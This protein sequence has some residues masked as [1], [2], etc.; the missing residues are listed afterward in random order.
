MTDFI[1]SL[2]RTWVAIA[3]GWLIS[4]GV[5]SSSLSD[6]AVQALTGAIIGLYYLVVRLLEKKWPIF[7]WL[8]GI[9]K[10]PSYPTP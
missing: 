9:A 4:V 5:L 8:L 10:E 2:V 1:T 6:P 7:G 3:V